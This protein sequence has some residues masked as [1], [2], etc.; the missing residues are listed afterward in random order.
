MPRKPSEA[1]VRQL[2]RVWRFEVVDVDIYALPYARLANGKVELTSDNVILAF[3]G[4]C[5]NG[6]IILNPAEWF[7]LRRTSRR[8]ESN[9]QYIGRACPY[10]FCTNQIPPRTEYDELVRKGQEVPE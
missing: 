7:V 4:R 8:Q 5:G 6:T 2:R 1:G 3:C 9:K 10:C